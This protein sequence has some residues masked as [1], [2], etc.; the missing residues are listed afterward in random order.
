M[1]PSFS[2][3]SAMIREVFGYQLL[4]KKQNKQTRENGLVRAQQKKKSQGCLRLCRAVSTSA[5]FDFNL[6]QQTQ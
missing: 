4:K 3:Q 5:I 2:L 6:K 1:F